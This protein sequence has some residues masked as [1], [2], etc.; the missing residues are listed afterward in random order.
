MKNFIIFI[1]CFAAQ[2]AFA[3]YPCNTRSLSDVT[4]YYECVSPTY[5]PSVSLLD[6]AASTGDAYSRYQWG[7]RQIL[8][9]EPYLNVLSDAPRDVKVAVIDSYVGHHGHPDLVDV[10]EQG[11][12]T[13]EGGT[14][15][16]AVWD[17]LPGT[18]SNEHGQCV[19]SII[20]AKHNTTGVAGV[21]HRARIIPVRASLRTIAQAIDAAVAAGAE[22]IHIAGMQG[23]NDAFWPAPNPAYWQ[24][25]P[26]WPDL[27]AGQVSPQPLRFMSRTE[28]ASLHE[29]GMLKA[30]SAAIER[31]VWNHNVIITTVVSNWDGQISTIFHAQNHE[32]VVAQ[33]SNVKGES[34]PLNSATHT[35]TILAPGGERRASSFNLPMPADILIN[36]PASNQDD[37]LCAIGPNK[38]SYA[39]G[40]SFAGPHV[41]AAAAIIK[42]Y[43]PNATATDVRRLLRRS[44]QPLITTNLTMQ[45][46]LP[47]MLSIKRLKQSIISEQIKGK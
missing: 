24:L 16:E 23:E 40:G 19:A 25:Y 14:N 8:E 1:C 44:A 17:G 26:L 4:A 6:G 5:A 29:N 22:V 15:T 41:A 37:I 38:Y 11:I 35:A 12:N 43:L 27:N 2:A 10:F 36:A 47:G 28:A 45:N 7:M 46:S 9:G 33:A 34:S 18:G 21:F 30:F 31:A 39:S 42:S 3:A 13:V 32:T 20:A